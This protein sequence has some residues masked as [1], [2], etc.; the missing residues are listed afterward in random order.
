MEICSYVSIDLKIVCR[1]L[2]QRSISQKLMSC[3]AVT[4]TKALLTQFVINS[5]LFRFICKFCN[6]I[7]FD[8]NIH[9]MYVELVHIL[10]TKKRMSKA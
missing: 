5:I 1:I 4:H 7:G 8:L 6:C 2:K 10:K 3:I 9:S